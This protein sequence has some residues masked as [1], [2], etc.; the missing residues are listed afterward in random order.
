M[1]YVVNELGGERWSARDA[2]NFFRGLFDQ[3]PV[4][5]AWVDRQHHVAYTEHFVETPFGRR[6]RFPFIPRNDRGLVARQGVN[7]PIQST[8]SDITLSALIRIHNRFREL[9]E[10]KGELV[11]HVILSIQD[12]VLG[13][14]KKFI[15]KLVARIV[16]EEMEDH[17]PLKSKV[18]FKAEIH[19]GESWTDLK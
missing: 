1:N 16:R 9:N 14:C 15:R 6:R 17:V 18:P 12:S 5:K 10:A 3:Y 7:T 8:A 4:Y 11:A 13:E 2:E 19:F